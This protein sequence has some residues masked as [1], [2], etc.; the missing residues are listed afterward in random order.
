MFFNYCFFVALAH[1][2]RANLHAG[3]R[4]PRCIKGATSPMQAKTARITC[5]V[6]LFSSAWSTPWTHSS[7]RCE[8]PAMRTVTIRA[9]AV[10]RSWSTAA[11]LGMCTNVSIYTQLIGHPLTQ[12]VHKSGK[13]GT[14]S[15]RECQGTGVCH[16]AKGHLGHCQAS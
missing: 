12:P 5:A 16:L 15:H 7:R 2:V 1:S 11:V 3:I 14:W 6:G 13:A 10:P 9:L 8:S 4:W